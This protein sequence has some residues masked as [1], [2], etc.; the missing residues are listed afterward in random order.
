MST[1]LDVGKRLKRA[2]AL[3]R[4]GGLCFLTRKLSPPLDAVLIS[5]CPVVCVSTRDNFCPPYK[6]HD[7]CTLVLVRM[8][9][10]ACSID[11]LTLYT[12][13][14]LILLYCK[15]TTYVFLVNKLLP[16]FFFADGLVR[17][18]PPSHPPPPTLSLST[19]VSV[20]SSMWAPI[21][22]P[23][24]SKLPPSTRPT[25]PSPL[26]KGQSAGGQSTPELPPKHLSM[27]TPR[28]SQTSLTGHRGV[29]SSHRGGGRQH[30]QVRRAQSERTKLSYQD[31]VTTEMRKINSAKK[32]GMLVHQESAPDFVYTPEGLITYP[33]DP[34]NTNIALPSPKVIAVPQASPLA[35]DG[36]SLE[37]RIE[38]IDQFQ[39]GKVSSSYPGGR[40]GVGTTK[41]T[42]GEEAG[43]GG[44]GGRGGRESILRGRAFEDDKEEPKFDEEKN[45]FIQEAKQWS[46]RLNTNSIKKV[47]AT[48]GS[49]EN[50]SSNASPAEQERML[51][52]HFERV[53]SSNQL[54]L[55]SLANQMQTAGGASAKKSPQPSPTPPPIAEGKRSPSSASSSASSSSSKPAPRLSPLRIP[56]SNGSPK[57]SPIHPFL[58]SAGNVFSY[59][60]PSST[61]LQSP[62]AA[63]AAANLLCSPSVSQFAVASSL[64]N[65]YQMFSH[66]QHA[67]TP[68]SVVVTDP[69][70]LQNL[71]MNLPDR[72]PCM[73]PDGSMTFFSINQL[74]AMSAAS[75]SA[76]SAQGGGGVIAEGVNGSS[77]GNQEQQRSQQYSPGKNHK[78]IRSPESDT[79]DS[80]FLPLPKRRRSTSLPDISQFGAAATAADS[81]AMTPHQIGTGGRDADRTEEASRRIKHLPLSSLSDSRSKHKQN[82]PIPLTRDVSFDLKFGDPMLSFPTPPSH[83]S[84][85]MIGFS[86]GSPFPLTTP[87]AALQALQPMTPVT[88]EPFSSEDMKDIIEATPTGGLPEGPEGTSLPQCRFTR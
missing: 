25:L 34:R 41:K 75:S 81:K 86:G 54:S 46:D 6:S 12:T 22:S 47:S 37:H 26:V 13:R 52:Q 8:S 87:T 20:I 5:P 62:A 7:L 33:S 15:C 60:P 58:S 31:R 76:N 43:G 85:P 65:P 50:I 57:K 56:S 29:L 51:Q 30:P 32:N 68:G 18:S 3:Y 77:E 36:G 61:S 80:R 70:T 23:S 88:P 39:Q 35:R 73:L 53:Q 40:G 64:F 82:M 49:F 66:Q 84:S 45:R 63:A 74:R 28:S 2:S 14:V 55:G 1:C 59:F 9:I 42:A 71:Q 24:V 19:N 38:Y 48:L 27:L 78:R 11:L 44:G 67:R 10:S 21:V 16:F 72:I 79:Q 69:S 17:P 83:Q 4:E